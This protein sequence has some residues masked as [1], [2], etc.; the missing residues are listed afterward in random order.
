MQCENVR[1]CGICEHIQ[2]PDVAKAAWNEAR[3]LVVKCVGGGLQ[4]H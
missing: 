2:N 1:I 4:H 3:E